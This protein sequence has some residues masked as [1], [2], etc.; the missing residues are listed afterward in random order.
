M[1]W[2]LLVAMLSGPVSLV[3]HHWLTIRPQQLKGAV[4]APVANEISQLSQVAA[5]V[6]AGAVQGALAHA[7]A[8]PP[9][10]PAGVARLLQG[11][12]QAEPAIDQ[13]EQIGAALAPKIVTPGVVQVTRTAEGLLNTETA[14][15]GSTGFG[16]FGGVPGQP[17]N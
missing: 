6:A 13:A 2:T 5:N 10:L 17:G 4:P 14:D 11:V 12:Q 15:N 3:V 1:N 7:A 8:H 9:A 16:A